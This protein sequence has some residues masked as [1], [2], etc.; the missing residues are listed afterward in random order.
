MLFIDDGK[1]QAT[2]FDLFLNHRMG[3]DHDLH[4]SPPDAVINLLPLRALDVARQQG[5]PN[6]QGF[7]PAVDRE[8]MLLGQHFG[9]RHDGGLIAE[10]HRPQAGQEGHNRLSASHISLNQT[11]HG[12]R[13]FHILHNLRQG[14]LL[15]AR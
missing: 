11:V 5:H 7:H 3:S 8:I 4:L 2:K 13:F 12:M 9:R 6:S 14:P 15:G 1:A 10:L